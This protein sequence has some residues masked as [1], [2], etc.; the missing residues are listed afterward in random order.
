MRVDYFNKLLFKLDIWHPKFLYVTYQDFSTL[1]D[2]LQCNLPWLPLIP[3]HRRLNKSPFVPRFYSLDVL[4]RIWLLPDPHDHRRFQKMQIPSP[5]SLP[6]VDKLNKYKEMRLKYE[7]K[8]PDFSR[9]KFGKLNFI[10][11]SKIIRTDWK[12]VLH[13][14]SATCKSKIIISVIRKKQNN[15][16]W[17]ISRNELVFTSLCRNS[18]FTF[19]A[20]CSDSQ[21]NS[22]W[23][24]RHFVV[25]FN[26]TFNLQFNFECMIFNFV[27]KL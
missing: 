6:I 24:C 11:L 22:Y 13:I 21:T 18:N 10:K 23:R 3:H 27:I 25:L 15:R 2:G 4:S 5:L 26:I 7:S 12:K 14:L 19:I 16:F 8:L 9:C 17:Q 1:L 20:E